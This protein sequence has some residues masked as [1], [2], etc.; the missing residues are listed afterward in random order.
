MYQNGQLATLQEQW[1]SQDSFQQESYSYD[2]TPGDPNDGLLSAITLQQWNGSGWE[3]E[4]EVTYDYYGSDPTAPGESYGLTG[5]LKTATLLLPGGGWL[6][7]DRRH[8]LLP[9]LHERLAR[10]C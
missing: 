10:F 6:D 5:D 1:P 7:H 3:N 2:S 9:L 8:V 4:R